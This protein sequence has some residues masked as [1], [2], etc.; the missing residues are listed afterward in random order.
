M[1][2]GAKEVEIMLDSSEDRVPPGKIYG[3]HTYKS[4]LKLSNQEMLTKAHQD[5]LARVR[6]DNGRLSLFTWSTAFV[7]KKAVVAT[8]T[9]LLNS[10]VGQKKIGEIYGD[11]GA[12]AVWDEQA[13]QLFK[14]RFSSGEVV[15]TAMS[16]MASIVVIS[17]GKN[18]LHIHTCFPV[19]GNM[20]QRQLADQ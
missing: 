3:G 2:F 15:R 9:A 12:Q 7:D 10:Q 5:Y 17:L 8:A 20:T 13:S 19:L 4:H 11:P 18:K 14:M 6:N 16:Q 1:L